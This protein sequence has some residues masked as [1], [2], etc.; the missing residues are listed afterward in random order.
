MN[1]FGNFSVI[2]IFPVT[3]RRNASKYSS[4]ISIIPISVYIFYFLP[5]LKYKN[6]EKRRAMIEKHNSRAD[7][8]APRGDSSHKSARQRAASLP[9]PLR[10]ALVF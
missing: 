6:L 1:F 4:T 7:C 5:F 10:S 2:M 3:F 8:G 9:R